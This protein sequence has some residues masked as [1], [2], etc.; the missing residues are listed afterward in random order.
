MVLL[1]QEIN[2]RIELLHLLISAFD[3]VI[4][5]L[6]H[7]LLGSIVLILLILNHGSELVE[8]ILEGDRIDLQSVS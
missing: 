6:V 4:E 8:L 1:Y 3:V 2:H 7:A 5:L